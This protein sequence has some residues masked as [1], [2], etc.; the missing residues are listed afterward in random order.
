MSKAE[1]KVRKEVEVEENK[2]DQTQFSKVSL[3]IKFIQYFL[4][5]RAQY[6]QTSSNAYILIHKAH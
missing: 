5:H 3:R 4:D 6:Q 1:Q 2:R